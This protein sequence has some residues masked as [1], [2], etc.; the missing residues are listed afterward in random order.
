M[1]QPNCPSTPNIPKI[2]ECFNINK[3]SIFQNGRQND[4]KITTSKQTYKR[5]FQAR[6]IKHD[7]Y[8]ILISLSF[9]RS[10]CLHILLRGSKFDW[11][12]I[13]W[14][15]SSFTD[16]SIFFLRMWKMMIF[17]SRGQQQE[18]AVENVFLSIIFW[19]M[20]RDDKR[21][22]LH[23]VFYPSTLPVGYR[24][25]NVRE[26]RTGEGAQKLARQHSTLEYTHRSLWQEKRA[27]L[28]D[29]WQT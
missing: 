26:S 4:G 11:I 21:W 24:P 23:S 14:C 12:F 13:L 22:C 29:Q 18:N 27:I 3:K 20:K 25:W 19:R 2:N 7:A 28:W 10:I 15:F 9:S 6:A 16:N 1:I 8:F 17:H 5:D